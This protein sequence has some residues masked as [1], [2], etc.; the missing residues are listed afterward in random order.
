[1]PS[2]TRIAV[3]LLKPEDVIPHLG[4]PTHWKQGRSA[5]AVADSWFHANDLPPRVRAVLDQ[6]PALRSAE[7]VDAWLERCT[8]LVRCDEQGEFHAETNKRSDA[9]R[10]GAG[11]SQQDVLHARHAAFGDRADSQVI[12][13][14]G[15]S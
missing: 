12:E 11:A 2:L 7:L 10:T 5:K 9:Y 15:R 1:M 4:K 14:S 8:D 13:H 6:S 3:P